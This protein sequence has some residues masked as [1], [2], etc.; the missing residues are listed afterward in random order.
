MFY[1]EDVHLIE[2]TILSFYVMVHVERYV[3]KLNSPVV[4]LNTIYV[5]VTW[6]F[7]VLLL[8]VYLSYA[9]EAFLKK[10]ILN[11]FA[12]K[13]IYLNFQPLQVV[14][15]YRDPQPKVDE[16]YPVQFETKHLHILMFKQ[17]FYSQ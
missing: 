9:H 4:C 3:R 11:P 1:S 10:L 7:S 2:N 17:S 5:S 12:A 13:L 8:S 6:T 16:N 15:R 14:S